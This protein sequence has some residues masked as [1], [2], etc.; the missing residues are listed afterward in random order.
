MTNRLALN[1]ATGSVIE[2]TATTATV[3][4][5]RARLPR[6]VSAVTT[7][8]DAALS[9]RFSDRALAAVDWIEDALSKVATLAVA[10]HRTHECRAIETT[11]A[12]ALVG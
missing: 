11:L 2:R 6:I 3:F 12:L 9:L 4:V 8:L 5:I 1:R 7:Q 10:A